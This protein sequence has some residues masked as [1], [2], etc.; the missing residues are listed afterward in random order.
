MNRALVVSLLLWA[1]PVLAADP[2]PPEVRKVA[3]AYL[4]AIA[5]EGDDG[6]RDLLLGGATI[7]AQLFTLE[8]W[9][10]L[11]KQPVMKEQGDLGS[12]AK[13]VADLD[14]SGEQAL[15]K[16]L[17]QTQEGDELGMTE[18]DKDTATRLLAPTK[19][20]AERLSQQH[21][22]LAY[23]VR[24]GKEVYWHPKNPM[25]AALAKAGKSGPY[26]LEL[27]LY[28]VET[29]EGP[30]QEKREWPLRVLRFKT[31]E[32]D[33]GWRVLPASDWNAE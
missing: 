14:Q 20:K 1:G 3:L 10:I 4:K 17:A 27:H 30:R 28:K 21:P 13:L 18:I 19:K 26:S 22:V 29:K 25:R 5:Q 8:N 2:E 12:A 6:G 7:N 9:R 32:F 33:T 31:A 15:A 11:S 16:V 24:V 23:A